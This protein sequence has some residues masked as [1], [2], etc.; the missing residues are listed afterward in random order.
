MTKFDEF[1]RYWAANF[2]FSLTDREG[3]EVWARFVN[4]PDTDLNRLKRVLEPLVER[5]GEAIIDMR[6]ASKLVPSLAAVKAAYFREAERERK[7]HEEKRFGAGTVCGVCRGTGLLVVLAPL[8]GDGER[9][10]WPEDFREHKWREFR[11]V[12]MAKCPSCSAR[13][14]PELRHRIESN[15][16]PLSV[17]PGDP[18]WPVQVDE[19]CRRN[20]RPTL[21]A[22]SGD[23]AIVARMKLNARG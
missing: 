23:Q 8:A 15:G 20:N 16:L 18:D 19:Y 4:R 3:D 1:N 12:E 22:M 21:T 11:G 6:P 10:R 14:R 7:E 2:G 5:Y 9:I 13:Y 17:R